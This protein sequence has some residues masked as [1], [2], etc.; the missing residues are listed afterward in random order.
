ALLCA[1][2]AFLD[3]RGFFRSYLFAWLGWLGIPLGSLMIVLVHQLTG[4]RWGEPLQPVL[5]ATMNTLPL[6]ALLFVVIALG[7]Q[8]IYVWSCPGVMSQDEILQKKEAYLNVPRFLIFAGIYFAVWIFLAVRYSQLY[9][10]WAETRDEV[11]A[12][13]VRR[14]SAVGL[15]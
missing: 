7:M 8:S 9:R 6:F 11:R 10:Q 4:G 2:G 3:A 1:A 12:Y 14:L 5:R 13:R 15:V